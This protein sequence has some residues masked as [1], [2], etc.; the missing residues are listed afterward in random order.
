MIDISIIIVNYNVKYFVEQCIRSIYAAKENLNIEVLVVDNASSD[1]SVDYLSEQFPQ[2]DFISNTQNAGFGRANNQALSQ[3]QGKYLLV[4]NPDTLLGEDSLRALYDYMESHPQTGAIGPKILTRYG[5]FDKASKRGLPTP[6]V[7]F[8]KISGL[9]S[10]FPKSKLFGKYHLLY[11]DEDSSNPVDS[12]SGACMFVRREVYEQTGGFDEDYFMYGEDIDW[13]FRIKQSGWTVEYAPV[14]KIVHFQGE[15][16]RRSTIDRHRAFYGAMHIFVEKH[17]RTKYS[18]FGHRLIDLGILLAY[19]IARGKV[20]WGKFAIPMVD[21]I[22]MFLLLV[23]GRWLRTQEF[24]TQAGLNRWEAFSLPP[25]VLFSL[26]VQALIWVSALAGTGVYRS[27]RGNPRALWMGIFLG[28]L[29]NSSF[30][31][32]FKQFAYS[33]FV[34]LFGLLAGALFLWGWRFTAKQLSGSRRWSRIMK[35]RSL[36]VGTGDMG[37]LVIDQLKSN[38]SLPY[39]SVGFIDPE[40]KQV[41]SLVYGVPV[42][43]GEEDLMRLTEQE[44]IEEILFAYDRLDYVKLLELVNRLGHLKG[45]N[46]K[47]ITPDVKDKSETEIPLLSPDYLAPRGFFGSLKKITTIAFKQ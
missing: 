28:F 46:F 18:W 1:G 10:L 5:S 32:F 21:Y 44:N 2:V 41:G 39:L 23:A 17:F 14:T 26:L 15:S 24:W 33:R 19:L 45:I 11:L 6:W 9:A 36:I 40:Q 34:I 8:C 20:L 47:L 16:T 22:G 12:L 4:L 38:D 29:V 31:Y 3:A 35:R 30:T 27:Q 25:V 42:L 7:S 13:S 37:K 43:G